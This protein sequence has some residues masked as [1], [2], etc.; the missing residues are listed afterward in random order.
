MSKSPV[1]VPPGGTPPIVAPVP[2][3]PPVP[4]GG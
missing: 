1:A 3:G 2:P 4:D